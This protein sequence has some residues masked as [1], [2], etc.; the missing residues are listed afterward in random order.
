MQL[1]NVYRAVMLSGWW[2]MACPHAGDFPEHMVGLCQK[3]KHRR[4]IGV[5]CKHWNSPNIYKLNLLL[6]VMVIGLIVQAISLTITPKSA[7][8]KLRNHNNLTDTA[9]LQDFNSLRSSIFCLNWQTTSTS[10]KNSNKSCGLL[11]FQRKYMGVATSWAINPLP[12]RQI[13]SHTVGTAVVQL[14]SLALLG[15]LKCQSSVRVV[16]GIR[17]HGIWIERNDIVIGPRLNLRETSPGWTVCIPIGY[18]NKCWASGD[19]P[20]T[21]GRRYIGL[22]PDSDGGAKPCVDCA[23]IR[24]QDSFS[25]LTTG[26]PFCEDELSTRYPDPLFSLGIICW[27]DSAAM[28]TGVPNK[29]PQW[30]ITASKLGS[31]PFL[32]FTKVVCPEA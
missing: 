18:V 15:I 19:V 10:P 14:Y 5:N 4:C 8:L 32:L 1:K 29:F 11:V 16:R 2:L 24:M 3:H 21:E 26:L 6:H 22:L 30:L 20:V 28:S 12:L 31:W 23:A 13:A 7:E 25:V 9:L 17:P 27:L